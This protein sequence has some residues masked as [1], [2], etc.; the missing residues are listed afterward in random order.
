MVEWRLVVFFLIM[1]TIWGLAHWY[2]GR[3]LIR[4]LGWPKRHRRMAWA[5]VWLAWSLA[6]LVMVLGRPLDGHPAFVPFMWAGFVYMGLFAALF[7]LLV[8]RDLGAA[9]AALWRR[10]R[11]RGGD[12]SGD[13]PE[14][15][16]R[17]RFLLNATNAGV[18]GASAALAGWGYWEARRMAEVV[19]V[20]VPVAGLPP[21]LDG[22][23]I[24][25][26]TDIHIGPT[27]KGDFLDGV[28][29]VVNGLSPDLIAVTGDLVD[30]YV[31][32]LGEHVAPLARLE[33]TDGVYFVT[34]NHEY[35]WDVHAWVQYVEELGLSVLNNAH[36]VVER[37]AA[38]LVVA[39]VTDYTAERHVAE[40]ASDPA[41]ALAGAPTADFRLLLAHQPKSIHAA[42]DA[43]FDL[44]VSGH[45]HGGQF[46]PYTLF[47]GLAHP[48]TE[49]L[50]R[51][52]DTW[53]Y[54]SRG[55]GY[56]GP[57]LRAGAPSEITL[58][59]LRSA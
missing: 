11:R 36:R 27:I 44:Q 47:V 31:S 2:A 41:R 14:V 56:W 6:P 43:G 52:R 35:Y 34:G 42:A 17:R 25:Q 51:L 8:F 23:R 54:V 59:T 7:P 45:T 10:L 4:P 24:A 1:G 19:E 32:Q 58:L 20:D 21:E 28:V 48:F 37:G 16:A 5:G 26:V 12:E 9:A 15:V 53:I 49:G 3:R 57:P 18:V 40:H 22:Y 55:T 46:F 29:E 50:G 30:G 13:E 33:A 38:R 39:G